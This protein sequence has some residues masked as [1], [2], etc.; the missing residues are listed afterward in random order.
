MQEIGLMITLFTM[1]NVEVIQVGNIV[2]DTSIG[3]KNPQRGRIYS[4]EGLAPC[5]NCCGGGGLEP[6]IVV[7]EQ[8]E[9]AKDDSRG[10]NPQ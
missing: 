8:Q 3:F 9:T 6:K 1:N 2:D 10:E 4:T 7:Y 5:L